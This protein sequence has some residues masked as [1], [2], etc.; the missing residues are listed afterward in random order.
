MTWIK[1]LKG[2]LSK[3]DDTKI[4]GKVS[5]DKNI[6]RLQRDIDRLSKWATIWQMEYNVGKCEIV[7]FGR[8]NKK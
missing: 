2:W 3:R 5:R 6:R 1:G 4:E 8:K 7:N